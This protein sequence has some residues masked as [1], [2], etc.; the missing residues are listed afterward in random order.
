[1]TLPSFNLFRYFSRS[2]VGP[3]LTLFR[4]GFSVNFSLLNLIAP[5]CWYFLLNLEDATLDDGLM[6]KLV[7]YLLNLIFLKNFQRKKKLDSEP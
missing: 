2:P 7:F 1:M 6:Q 4:A 5:L 3:R